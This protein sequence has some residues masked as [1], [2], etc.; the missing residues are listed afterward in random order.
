MELTRR[1]H[2]DELH[3]VGT[4]LFPTALAILWAASLALQDTR[5]CSLPI[6]AITGKTTCCRTIPKFSPAETSQV[7]LKTSVEEV[8]LTQHISTSC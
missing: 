7:Q 5:W 3:E 8:L 1:Y 6:L 2:H 4:N